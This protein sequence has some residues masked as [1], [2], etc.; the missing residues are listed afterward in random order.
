MKLSGITK[1]SLVISLAYAMAGCLFIA[2]S[3]AHS[4][5]GEAEASGPITVEFEH[6]IDLV[7]VADG[8][9]KG[10]RHADLFSAAADANLEALVGWKGASF[11]VHALSSAGNQ[12]NELAGTL[13]GINN[14]EV[15][16]N[17]VKIFQAYLTQEFSALPLTLTAGLVDLNAHYYANDSAGL[18]LNPAFG[19]GSELSATGPNGPSIFPAAALTL[20]AKFTPSEHTYAQFAVV[21]G[22]AGVSG[23]ANG[24]GTLFDS[25]ALLISE[26]G[27][28]A[29]GKLAL[30]V[31]GY[32]KKHDDL[33]NLDLLGNPEKHC[34]HGAYALFELPFGNTEGQDGANSTFFLRAGISEGHTT[35]FKGGWQAGF[36]FNRLFPSRP[37][38]QLTI[39][40]NQAYLSD[41]FRANELDGA[42]GHSGAETGFEIAYSD[43]IAPWL[44]VQPDVQYIHRSQTS[45]SVNDALVFSLRLTF[46]QASDL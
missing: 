19:I 4:E 34:A 36:L 24:N 5:D 1:N 14:S 21:N 40:A 8:D 33:R 12:P 2:S 20:H 15:D 28:T 42:I 41:K 23:N 17:F 29:F 37:D 39:G 32:S 25:G 26:A 45:P 11:S 10:T 18:L 3:P 27:T 7:T 22:E 13:Q 30:G 6:K 38:S 16:D 9:G 44:T 46:T 31:W 35:P 43:K